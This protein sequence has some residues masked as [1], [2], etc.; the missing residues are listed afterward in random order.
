M[1][2]SED[3][4]LNSIDQYD[5][6][7]H[8]CGNSD[9]A[10]IPMGNGELCTNVWLQQD[11]LHFYLSRSDAITELDRVVKL[12]E[13]VVSFEPNPFQNQ[14][15]V[16][17]TLKLRDGLLKIEGQIQENNFSLT[18]FIDSETDQAVLRAE[19]DCDFVTTI[20]IFNW[21]KKENF[22]RK[23]VGMFWGDENIESAPGLSSISESADRIIADKN[24]LIVYH[25][26]NVSIVPEI[27]RLHG[28]SEYEEKIPDLIINRKFGS[29]ISA[30]P[31]AVVIEN[32]IQTSKSR[33]AT[34]RV[35]SFSS[36]SKELS[37]LV[38][39][40]PTS[41]SFEA[42]MNQTIKHW[43]EYWKRSWV[44]MTGDEKI[45]PEFTQDVVAFAAGNQLPKNLSSTPSHVTRAYLLTKW[46]T[47][48]G[49]QGAMPI[50]YNGA[51]F[52]TMPGA[53]T[54]FNLDSFAK[55]FTAAPANRP[56]LEFNPDE[57][58]WTIEHLWQN[59]RLPYFSMLSRGEPEGL[60]PLFA[61][62][63]RF[64]T[65]N[66]TRARIHHGAEGQWNTEMTLSCGLQ[67]PGI[68]GIERLGVPASWSKNQWG[69]SINLS[70]GLE[71]CKLMFDFWR[72][73]ANKEFLQN[74]VIPYALDLIA[75]AKSKYFSESQN[76]IQF[77]S[78][79]SLETYF[80]CINPVAIV[81]GYHRLANDLLSISDDLF[82]AK[83][84]IADFL[85]LLPEIPT[86]V[87]EMGNRFISPAEV[88]NPVR[89]NV[90]S[91]ELYA[92]Y[93]FDL[94]KQFSDE[95]LHCT[96]LQALR[97]SGSF[98]PAVIGEKLGSASFSGWQY[99]GQTA[100]MLGRIDEAF[101]V[102]R[103]NATL[104]NPGHAFPA[105]WGPIYDSV[106]DVDHGANILIA[107]QTMLIE[108][109]KDPEL[110]SKL[111]QSLKV[112]FKLFDEFGNPLKGTIEN[113]E[114]R[115]ID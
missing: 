89:M 19:S 16:Y 94:R 67:S 52:T 31:D 57:R 104:T 6:I 49:N 15:V 61:F 96:W 86:A 68:Y 101:T 82:D 93:P 66:R 12:G 111:P 10:S 71:L 47:A 113:S 32:R 100:A 62:F 41:T 90:E 103:C 63:K 38:S 2:I 97:T 99:Q 105:M 88:F 30:E 51:L 81:C 55:A 3:T 18:F 85:K 8:G 21:R 50:H 56:S 28:L 39:E 7:F 13:Y 75:F 5:Q 1:Q 54:H 24:C 25:Q 58:S 22:A 45:D 9:R 87:D 26:N 102:I 78:L 107:V 46:M 69:G 40:F 48:C 34:V 17:Q 115:L 112:E 83:A 76:R 64:W 79:N 106:P 4:V 108:I 84:E 42:S 72:Y 114:L 110:A 14:S 74:E 92:I 27:V 44:F 36:Q 65:L 91:P 35:V 20:E 37:E 70:P 80:E 60:I 11:G 33:Q 23:S 53:G 73:T 95:L 98:R 109:A 29:H 43:N 77:N 59:L